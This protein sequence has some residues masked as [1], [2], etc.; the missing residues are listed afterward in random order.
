MKNTKKFHEVPI[1]DKDI[2]F[3]SPTKPLST[4]VN[5][6]K[7]MNRAMRDCIHTQELQSLFR[8]LIDD[9]EK[10]YIGSINNMNDIT[11]TTARRFA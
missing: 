1:K 3:I 10:E 7:E 5:S 6:F 9:L 8:T 4:I 2:K 11:P